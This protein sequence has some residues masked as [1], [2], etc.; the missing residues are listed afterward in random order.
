MTTSARD[1]RPGSSPVDDE[2]HLESPPSPALFSRLG[3]PAGMR[4]GLEALLVV[5]VVAPIVTVVYRLWDAHL[6]VP[7]NYTGDALSTSAYTKA[8]IEN[9]WYF[10]DPRL[11]APFVADW[12]DFPVG[13]ENLHWLALKVLGVASG[14]YAIAVNTYFLLS[15]FLIALS[16]YFVARYLRLGV[17]ASLV[18][19]V[20]YAF[21]PYHAFRQIAQLARGTYYVLPVVVLVLLWAADYRREFLTVVE[22]RTRWRRGR[23]WTAVVVC[24][25]LG[26]SDT[27]NAAFMASFLVVLAVVNAI[28]DRDWRPIAIFALLTAI[29]LGTL[30]LD[31]MPYLLARHE[32]G[33]NPRTA[34]R[35]LS[36]QDLYALRPV[37]LLLPAPGHRVPFLAHLAAKSARNQ[38]T[39]GETEGTSLGVVGSVGLLLSLGAVIASALGARR[40]DQ[41]G[42]LLSRLGILNVVAILIGT[43]GGFAFLLALAGFLQYRTWN[44]VSL[45]IAFAALLATGLLLDTAFAWIRRRA[46]G[47]RPATLIVVVITAVLVVGGAFDQITPRFVPNYAAIATHFEQDAAF[48]RDLEHRLPR[49]AMVFQLPVAEFPEVGPIVNMPDYAQFAGYLHTDHLRFN[50]GGMKGRPHADWIRNLS[51]CDPRQLVSQIAAAGFDATVLDT[52]G[53][54]DGG[55]SFLDAV[56]PL[57]GEPHERSADGHL[58]TL[59]L[60]PLRSRMRAQVGDATVRDWPRRRRRHRHRV[61][62]VHGR[63]AGVP[64]HPA[65]GGRTGPVDHDHE[66][67]RSTIADPVHQRR[68][69]RPPRRARR[70]ARSRLLPGGPAHR[71]PRPDR[72]DAGGPA[73]DQPPAV[74]VHRPAGADLGPGSTPTLV[75]AARREL[76]AHRHPDARELGAVGRCWLSAAQSAPRAAR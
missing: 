19:G 3:F 27:Q 73:R 38:A 54:A 56:R 66:L 31:N 75:R 53:Y 64:G 61:A 12:R 68:P 9:G 74:P 39:N 35:Y 50:Y 33:P 7:F 69:G 5:T 60:A 37:N 55:T 16:A 52:R 28:R 71:R 18:V 42:D 44:R 70:P 36:D 24:V 57:V 48:Y 32:L 1:A 29:A 62:R 26:A 59:D 63:G 20:L 30:A 4:P 22:G 8:I 72:P 2:V 6:R 51:V 11:G 13:G 34:T 43:I 25:V 65:L 58:L 40:R 10:H 14:D 45:F 23:V 21:L 49:G 46:A 76:R 47:T 15:F 67:H 17:A 41:A